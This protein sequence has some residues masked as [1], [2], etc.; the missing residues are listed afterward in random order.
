[1][2]NS[3]LESPDTSSRGRARM[4]DCCG[5]LETPIEFALERVGEEGVRNVLQTVWCGDAN[6]FV[7]NR[8]VDLRRR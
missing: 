1:M 5:V 7:L 8:V 4:P 2:G 6:I 3:L